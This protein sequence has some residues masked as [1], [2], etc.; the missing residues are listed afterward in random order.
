MN[1][2]DF[3]TYIHVSFCLL[4]NYKGLLLFNFF[5]CK[6]GSNMPYAPPRSAQSLLSR[7]R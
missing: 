1:V 5:C 7:L 3:Y 2:L 4:S 6:A